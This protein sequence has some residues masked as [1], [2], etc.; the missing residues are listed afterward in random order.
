MT[1]Q[2]LHLIDAACRQHEFIDGV[3]VIIGVIVGICISLG[4]KYKARR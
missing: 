4:A 1:C 3:L 2:E